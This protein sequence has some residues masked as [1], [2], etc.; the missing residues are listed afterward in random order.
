LQADNSCA[1]GS[2]NTTLEAFMVPVKKVFV[3]GGE[4]S[5]SHSQHLA[6]DGA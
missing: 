3:A 6:H 4:N 5:F 1:I 2:V